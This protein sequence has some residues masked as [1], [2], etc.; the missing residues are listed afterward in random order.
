MIDFV[1]NAYAMGPAPQGGGQASPFIQ[2]LPIIIMFLVFYFLI[3]MPQQKKAKKHKE[4]INSLKPGHK[5]LTAGGLYG[6]VTG[7]AEK[8]I[9]VEIAKNVSVKVSKNY[10]VAVMTGE[11]EVEE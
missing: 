4:M 3:I 8:A 5:V 10:V 11:F 1:T 2:L 7:V 6:T 9:T